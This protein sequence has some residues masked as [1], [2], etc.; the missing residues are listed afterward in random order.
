MKK[1]L[2]IITVTGLLFSNN[3]S[4]VAY[5]EFEDSFSLSRTYFT[6][7]TEVSDELSFKFQTDVGKVGDDNRW[8]GFL[9]KAQLDWKCD[10]NMKISMGMIG[11][12]MLNI[13]EKTWGNRFVSKSAMDYYG[14]SATADLGIG[15]YRNFGNISTSLLMTNGEG[16]INSDVDDENKL[17]LRVM[18]GEKN[19]NKNEGHN[20]GLVYSSLEDIT[21]TG[22]FGGWSKNGLVIGTEYNVEDNNGA[23]YSYSSHLSSIYL[24]YNL[25]DNISVFLRLDDGDENKDG[26]SEK[27]TLAGLIWMPTDGL[28]ICINS[29]SVTDNDVTEDTMK[30]NF[31]FKF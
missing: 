16:Y 24:N 18:M 27:R 2:L 25:K 19:L 13:Q 15:I 11:L 30:L 3:I 10:S 26:N 23:E 9:K 22:L 21:V 4:G 6:Y 29:S 20:F 28:D 5:F 14:Y 1:I 8:T 7:K 31:Q 17:S 12:N